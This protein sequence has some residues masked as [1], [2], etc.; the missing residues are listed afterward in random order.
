LQSAAES[1]NFL[2]DTLVFARELVAGAQEHMAEINTIISEKSIGWSIE[3]ITSVDK[4]ILRLAVYEILYLKTPA[5][6]VI[7]EAVNLAKK[8]ST[9]DSS[10]FVNGILGNLVK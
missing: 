5:S 2:E 6:V 4:A 8:F 7:N 3:R 10:K 9:E 1:E